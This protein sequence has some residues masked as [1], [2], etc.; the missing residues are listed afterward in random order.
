[1]Q[2]FAVEWATAN[3]PDHSLRICTESPSLLKAIE[4]RFPVTNNLS[5][6]RNARPGLTTLLWV[7]DHKGI[8]GNE[9]ADIEAIP[10]ATTYRLMRLSSVHAH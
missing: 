2:P 6:L 8:P 3:H 5:S 4:S 1:M 9:L 10:A 7:P